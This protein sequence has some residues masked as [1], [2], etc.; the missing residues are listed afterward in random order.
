MS[1]RFKYDS[2]KKIATG[3][4]VTYNLAGWIHEIDNETEMLR[5]P[6][7]EC[8]VTMETY[9]MAIGTAGVRFCPYCG[10]ERTRE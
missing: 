5:C 1:E 10:R 3:N 8:R 4:Y 2:K 7:C 6:N 9:L